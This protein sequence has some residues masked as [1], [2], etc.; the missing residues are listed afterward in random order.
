MCV[1]L[2]QDK[3]TQY[4]ISDRAGGL[5]GPFL[6]SPSCGD[7]VNPGLDYEAGRKTNGTYMIKG[8]K[9]QPNSKPYKLRSGVVAVACSCSHVSGI[10]TRRHIG[11]FQ[12]T[13]TVTSLFAFTKS[14]DR[15]RSS[16]LSPKHPMY[17]YAV[18]D[19]AGLILKFDTATWSTRQEEGKV[20]NV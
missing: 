17:E 13:S 19:A 20:A 11:K 18:N 16:V 2:K 15:T 6:G 7:T 3:H 8:D 1:D 14:P 10:A 9:D 4:D 12:L 5:R